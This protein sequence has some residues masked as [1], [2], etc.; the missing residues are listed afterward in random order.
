MGGKNTLCGRYLELSGPDHQVRG[1]RCDMQLTPKYYKLSNGGRVWQRIRTQ[2][3][4]TRQGTQPV[5]RF[6]PNLA[7]EESFTQQ[8]NGQFE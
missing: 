2:S 3:R 6:T 1:E 8:E 4:R 5:P 7:E